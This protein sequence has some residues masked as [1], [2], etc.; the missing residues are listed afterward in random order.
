MPTPH[1]PPRYSVKLRNNTSIRL[2]VFIV[3]KERGDYFEFEP[4]EKS[5]L[6]LEEGEYGIVAFEKHQYNI[7]STLSFHVWEHGQK[8]DIFAYFDYAANGGDGR[9]VK[10]D[11]SHTHS[12]PNYYPCKETPDQTPWN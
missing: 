3:S 12:I 10:K 2:R 8:I 9:W 1:H 11:D 5:I 7:L 6:L 4:F